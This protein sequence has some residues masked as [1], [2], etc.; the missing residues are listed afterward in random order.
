LTCGLGAILLAVAV[1]AQPRIATVIGNSAYEQTGWQLTNPE[2]D[3]RLM[4]DTLRAIGFDVALATNLDEDALEDI[5]AEHSERLSAAG[6]DAIGL[7]YYAGHG[8]QSQGANYLIPVDANPRTEQDVWRQAPRLGEA[9]R[10]IEAA[11]NAVNFII[12]DA[13][14]NNPL[15]SANRSAGGGLSAP[16]RARGLLIAYATEPGQ[17][18]ADGNTGNSPYTQALADILPSEGLI[19]EQVFRRVAG[20][21]NEATN[22]A[23]T[24]FFNSGLIGEG[25]ICFNAENCGA[26]RIEERLPLETRPDMFGD[27]LR[28]AELC[29]L[30]D[31]ES[32]GALATD[33]AYGEDIEQDYDAAI[34][35]YERACGDGHMVSCV[36]LGT[37]Y[38]AG[39]GV[40]QDFSKTLK[41]YKK[42]CD[43]ELV[44][45]CEALGT[46]YSSGDGVAQDDAE[47]LRIFTEA[48]YAGAQYSC[49]YAAEIHQ[50]G[51]E[52]VP[53]DYE[54]ASAFHLTACQRGVSDNCVYLGAFHEGGF[55][56]E[57]DLAAAVWFYRQ[58]C[59]TG[60]ML[61]CV[62]LGNQYATGAGVAQSDDIA[63]SYFERACETGFAP[64]CTNL[65]VFTLEG[66]GIEKNEAEG[67]RLLQFACGE[68]DEA[69]CSQI[70]AGK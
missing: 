7:L 69:A 45:G 8:V 57:K 49:A 10:Y 66:R 37:I 27:V 62:A 2:N 26:G 18:A 41:Y 29:D 47:A 56:V 31:A 14:R 51:G 21:V 60:A 44:L 46:L 54:T 12:L 30:G 38:R 17:T 43:G 52:G 36:G 23:Q 6:P 50:A 68:G 59:E 13:C 35:L 3:A 9:L 65:G 19:V 28:V 22:G 34:R 24:P 15:P 40:A 58:G 63:V 25:D 16:E 20:R 61:G 32:C 5:F 64:G 70:P 42:A 39:D 67:L 55:G 4:A 53:V 48:C 11:G 33:Y 1:H